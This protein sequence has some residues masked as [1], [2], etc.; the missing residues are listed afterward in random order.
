MKEID[1][2]ELKAKPI[3]GKSR[4][5]QIIEERIKPKEEK[6]QNRLWKLLAFI[7][8]VFFLGWFIGNKTFNIN[9][10]NPIQ[11]NFK[12]IIPDTIR[13]THVVYDTIVI[14]ENLRDR[15][16][17]TEKVVKAQNAR[18]IEI[19]DTLEPKE[20]TLVSQLSTVELN[21]KIDTTITDE[22]LSPK[23]NSKMRTSKIYGKNIK[24]DK[25]SV[26]SPYAQMNDFLITHEF[27]LS[28]LSVNSI[29][30]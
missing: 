13:K 14:A 17:K 15:P 11:Q 26:I 22:V 4:N 9:P 16:K 18:T 25:P 12:I 7:L 24:L 6:K 3:W 30:Q 2:Y 29:K 19:I 5:W 1:K 21:H 23:K 27:D 10:E 28:S 8:M 20:M